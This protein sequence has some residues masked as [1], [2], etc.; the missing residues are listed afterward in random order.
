MALIGAWPVL[1][2]ILKARIMGMIEG[3]T[4]EAR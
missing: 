2:E 3:A 1:P 4:G